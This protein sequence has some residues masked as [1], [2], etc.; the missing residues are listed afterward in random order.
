MAEPT[1]ATATALDRIQLSFD[2]GQLT[3]LTGVAQDAGQAPAVGGNAIP[4]LTSAMSTAAIRQEIE[5]R[6]TQDISPWKALGDR[7]FVVFVPGFRRKGLI[8]EPVVKTARGSLLE[9]CQ[10]RSHGDYILAGNASFSNAPNATHLELMEGLDPSKV[11]VPGYVVQNGQIVLGTASA[12][13]AAIQFQ[14]GTLSAA[15]GDPPGIGAAGVNAIGGLLPVILGGSK[16]IPGPRP[17][18]VDTRG[19]ASRKY[20]EQNKPAVGKNLLAYNSAWDMAAALWQRDAQ[21]NN[22]LYD[23]ATSM[24]SPFHSLDVMRDFLFD[25][26][27]DHAVAMD[28]SSSVFLYVYATRT[29]YHAVGGWEWSPKDNMMVVAYAIRRPT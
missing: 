13:R 3:L 11:I 1:T 20:P 4:A 9:L 23:A 14:N 16:F 19:W 29:A 2:T 7:L 17:A 8:F 18:G 22:G 21:V 24:F 28:G 25:L 5:A 15:S 27:F 26:G 12:D 10:A 6:T